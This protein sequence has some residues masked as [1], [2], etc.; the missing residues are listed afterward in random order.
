[1]FEVC[2]IHDPFNAFR[3]IDIVGKVVRKLTRA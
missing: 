3:M 2:L 1:M